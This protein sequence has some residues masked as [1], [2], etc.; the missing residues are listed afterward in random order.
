MNP[1][2]SKFA[3]AL[4]LAAT[5][6]PAAAVQINEIMYRPAPEIPEDASRE[7][8][9]L[10][11]EGTGTVN[12]L[13]WQFVNGISFTFTNATTLAPGGYLVVASKLSTFQADH[14][15]VTNVVG[16]WS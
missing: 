9:E 6:L 8:I 16:S 4:L 3:A 11:N 15:G 13:G 1:F 7:W 2:A 14:P 10:V 12:L 5:A